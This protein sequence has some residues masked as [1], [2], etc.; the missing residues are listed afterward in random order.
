MTRRVG[1]VPRPPV[2]RVLPV[3]RGLLVLPVVPV[4]PV[5]RVLPVLIR[6]QLV[7]WARVVLRVQP[8]PAPS[9]REALRTCRM[10]SALSTSTTSALRAKN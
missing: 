5:I 8:V 3:R 6:A 9:R 7:L 1:L 4:L 10:G 2:L